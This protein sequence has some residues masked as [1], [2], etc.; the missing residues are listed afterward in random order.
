M[1][2]NLEFQ[3]S[4]GILESFNPVGPRFWGPSPLSSSAAVQGIFA[5]RLL[6]LNPLS[7]GIFE[8]PLLNSWSWGTEAQREQ[9]ELADLA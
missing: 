7:P 6:G 2:W 4:A 8:L 9:V 1:Q 5:P 3:D